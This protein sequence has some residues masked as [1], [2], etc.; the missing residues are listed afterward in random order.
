VVVLA[1]GALDSPALLRSS[2]FGG[3]R[4]GRGLRLHPA[5]VVGATFP[6]P[7]TAWRGVPQSVIVEEFASFEQDG[8]GGFLLLPSAANTP[9]LAATLAPGIGRAHRDQ[10]RHY[11]RR[12]AAAVLLHDETEG[13]ILAGRGGRPVARYWPDA[14]D[15]AELIR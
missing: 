14:R 4:V 13:S 6:E 11:T 10:M 5:A 7:V 2:G 8:R 15:R 12:A 3:A 9:G 1:A